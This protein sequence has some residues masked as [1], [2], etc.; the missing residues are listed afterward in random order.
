MYQNIWKNIHLLNSQLNT[1]RKN[2][3]VAIK[4]KKKKLC[5]GKISFYLYG[6]RTISYYDINISKFCQYL[7][8]IFKPFICSAQIMGQTKLTQ[9]ELYT[10]L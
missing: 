2:I 10:R 8:I 9:Q 5:G 7:A 6:Y 1:A 4:D 3:A